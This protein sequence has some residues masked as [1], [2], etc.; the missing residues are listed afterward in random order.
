[1]LKEKNVTVIFSP[2]GV[3]EVRGR[4]FGCQMVCLHGI[5]WPFAV[6]GLSRMEDVQGAVFYSSDVHSSSVAGGGP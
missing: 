6:R 5:A 1:M 3:L 2:I 4:S